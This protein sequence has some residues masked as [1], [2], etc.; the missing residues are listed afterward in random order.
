M[1]HFADA[2]IWEIKFQH[3]LATTRVPARW[4]LNRREF[5]H[6]KMS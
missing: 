3:Y 6:Y 1:R 5:Y 4:H 2:L